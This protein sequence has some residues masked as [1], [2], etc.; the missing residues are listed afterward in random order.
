MAC[1]AGGRVPVR[2]G[3]SVRGVVLAGIGDL[4]PTREQL[5][6]CSCADCRC[7]GAAC[8]DLHVGHSCWVGDSKRP[9]LAGLGFNRLRPGCIM[10]LGRGGTVQWLVGNALGL[11]GLWS[12]GQP[13]FAWSLPPGGGARR[14]GLRVVAGGWCWRLVGG[15]VVVVGAYASQSVDW[16]QPTGPALAVRLVH[17]DLPTDEKQADIAQISALRLLGEMA[18][19]PGTDLTVFPELF[20]LQSAHQLPKAW[21]SEVMGS[22]KSAQ[23]ALLFGAPGAVLDAA[24]EAPLHQNT[25]VFIDG[26][27]GAKTYA[28]EILLPFSEYLPNTAWL[29]WAY[30]FLY[31]YPQADFVAGT[32]YQPP[33]SVRGVDL[34]VTI[35]SELAYAGK[36]SL[37]ARHAQILVNASADSWIPSGA[38]LRQAHQIARV[39][40]AEAQKP[41]VRANNVGY[42]AFIDHRGRVRSS[43]LGEPGSG[44]MEVV[45]R[46][47]VTP[48]VAFAAWAA[49]WGRTS[50]SGG[51]G[52]Q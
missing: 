17:T 5:G 51:D 52:V 25:L 38:Y 14:G 29:R 35:C 42:S 15:A 18:G 13:C 21:R 39:R 7:A 10:G 32:G 9:G 43:L 34:G 4:S 36:A 2:L 8:A 22:A 20:L 31:H 37:Q 6:L 49:Q 27:G 12:V 46:V 23:T 50:A 47:G 19:R 44:V 33:M 30:P 41:M 1:A 45:P 40:A 16:T 24:S 48:Y 28:K 26:A 11:V 3:L